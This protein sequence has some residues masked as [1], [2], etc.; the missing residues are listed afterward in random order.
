M[1]KTIRSA[2]VGLLSAEGIKDQNKMTAKEILLKFPKKGDRKRAGLIEA[3]KRKMSAA[4]A[5]PKKNASKRTSP[6]SEHVDDLAPSY[7]NR[8]GKR[9][10]KTIIKQNLSDRVVADH[11]GRKK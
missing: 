1:N 4:K 6:G 8:E 2:Q 11:R 9:W 10:I 3:M 5:K 7:V